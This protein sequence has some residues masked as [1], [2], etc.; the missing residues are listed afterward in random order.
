MGWFGLIGRFEWA[1]E[2]DLMGWFGWMGKFEQAR[3]SDWMGWIGWIGS[4]EHDGLGFG[5]SLYTVYFGCRFVD[6]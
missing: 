5:L 3:E 1:K 6:Y 2:S 4:L